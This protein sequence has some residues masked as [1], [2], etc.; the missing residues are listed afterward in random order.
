MEQ[1]VG[2]S[3]WLDKLERKVGQPHLRVRSTV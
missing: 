1:L 3:E 2:M